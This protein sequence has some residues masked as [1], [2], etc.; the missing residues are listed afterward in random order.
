[1]R[2]RGGEPWRHRPSSRG[3]SPGRPGRPSSQ[4]RDPTGAAS[5]A[6][7]RRASDRAGARDRD[8]G[9]RNSELGCFVPGRSWCCGLKSWVNR[10][11][12]QPWCCTRGARRGDDRDSCRRLSSD[13]FS[14]SRLGHLTSK[15]FGDDVFVVEISC[16]CTVCMCKSPG[17]GTEN[18]K[19]LRQISF[20]SSVIRESR[21]FWLFPVIGYVREAR[22]LG[23]H[24]A[25]THRYVGKC[26][27]VTR[28]RP[29]HHRR[30]DIRSS[31][32]FARVTLR[33]HIFRGT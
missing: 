8:R 28:S 6:A 27:S 24:N 22:A 33:N 14:E 3:R 21:N 13:I 11:V 23:R 31:K 2:E 29:V 5:L 1:M 4:I 17:V 9:A 32:T 10:G 20:P 30:V 19:V 16:L 25:R 18:Q 7:R 12:V 26:P 15:Q